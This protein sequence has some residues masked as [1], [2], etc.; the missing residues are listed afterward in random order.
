MEFR[1][2]ICTCMHAPI[3]GRAIASRRRRI[4]S[5][6]FRRGIFMASRRGCRHLHRL[7]NIY[8]LRSCRASVSDLSLSICVDIC[9]ALHACSLCWC[10][11]IWYDTPTR[12]QPIV[13]TPCIHPSGCR[14]RPTMEHGPH[15][16][17]Q[18]YSSV[19]MA[20]YNRVACVYIFVIN[21]N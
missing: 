5:R 14:L 1:G 11:Y 4:R 2:H 13:L 19:A 21:F 18:I 3:I 9:S 20:S 6:S 17:E 16:H 8:V 12:R 10:I 7:R 15:F